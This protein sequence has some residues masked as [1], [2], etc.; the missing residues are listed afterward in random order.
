MVLPR[1]EFRDVGYERERVSILGTCVFKGKDVSYEEVKASDR[2]LHL[3]TSPHKLDEVLHDVDLTYRPCP[4]EALEIHMK[5]A[6][7]SPQ[8]VE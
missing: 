3:F 6:T 1:D 7:R 4:T 2:R 8:R 5:I